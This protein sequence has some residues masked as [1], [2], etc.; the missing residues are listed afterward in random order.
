[1]QP[2]QC[3]ISP[4]W[5]RADNLSRSIEADDRESPRCCTW[6]HPAGVPGN[7]ERRPYHEASVEGGL[8]RIAEFDDLDRIDA[9]LEVGGRWRTGDAWGAPWL[10]FDLEVAGRLH[11]DSRERDAVVLQAAALAGARV[12]DRLRWLA[13]IVHR[14]QESRHGRVHDTRGLRLFLRPE[15]QLP[16]GAVLWL[17]TE[18]ERGDLVANAFPDPGW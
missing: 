16:G 11:R 3:W 9:A 1:M 14:Q 15:L 6:P 8:T 2:Q 10:G 17:R 7:L 18:A 5:S 12:T 13:G 4:G